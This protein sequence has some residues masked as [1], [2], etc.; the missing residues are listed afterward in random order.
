MNKEVDYL[1][2]ISEIKGMMERSSRFISLS[3]L[4]G[5]MAGIYALAGAYIAYSLI[6]SEQSFY[7][8]KR[9]EAS[10]YDTLALLVLDALIVLVLALGTGIYFTTKRATKQGLKIWDNTAKRLLIN[11]LIPLVTGGLFALILV[12]RGFVG[13]VAPITLI[14]YG[15]ALVNASKYTL[16]D[17]RY[18]GLSEILLGL[19]ASYYIGYGLLFWALGFGVLHIIYG[20]LM[21]YKYEK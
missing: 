15:L 7:S 12:L 20:T 21:Y 2:D 13:I 14:F 8:Y 9:I 17:V 19:L 6:Y 18:L 1:K 10:D 11:L 4:S 16:T 3:G 5:I